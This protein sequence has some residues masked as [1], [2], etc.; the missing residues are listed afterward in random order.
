MFVASAKN[1][2][3]MTKVEVD[4]TVRD[5]CKPLKTVIANEEMNSRV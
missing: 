5:Y 3:K 1:C 4:I 2:W